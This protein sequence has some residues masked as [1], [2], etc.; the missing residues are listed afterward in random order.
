MRIFFYCAAYCVDPG[1]PSQLSGCGIVLRF[2]DEGERIKRRELGFALGGSDLLLA[3]IQSVRLALSSVRPGHRSYESYAYVDNDEVI[4]IL[5]S[6][7]T[8]KYRTAAT[9]LRKWFSFYTNLRVIH[10]DKDHEFGK[11]ALELAIEATE[12]QEHFD[13]GSKDEY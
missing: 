4:E 10:D 7:D 8:T 6:D 9:E 3:Q 13:S 1:E 11:R 5:G 2:I 12:Q